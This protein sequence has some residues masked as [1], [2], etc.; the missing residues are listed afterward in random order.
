MIILDIFKYF[1]AFVPKDA[2]RRTFRVPSGEEYRK[3]MDA[4][5]AT[6]DDR[7]QDGITDY[8]FG[9]DQEKLSTVIGEVKGIY[10]FVE[11]DRVSSTINT[12]VD[13]KDDRVHVAVTVASPVPDSADLVGSS[14]V[15]DRCLEILSSI[16]RLMRD[17]DDLR[18]GITWMD[19]P[20]TLTVFSSKALANS[21]GW[22]MEFDIYGIDIV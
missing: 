3:L 21:Q 14:M 6:G 16:R 2:L 12:V 5:L 18:R 8:V 10:L 11:Y 22:S 1:A 15:Q 13:R 7:V 20:A 9:T 17:D 19:Y 4:V